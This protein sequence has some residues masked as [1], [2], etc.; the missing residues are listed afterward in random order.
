MLGGELFVPKIPSMTITDLAKTIAPKCRTKLVG[1]RPGEKLHE[2]MISADDARQTKELADCYI[3]QPAFPWWSNSNH[4]E[5]KD[6]SEG[7]SYSS[8]ANNDWLT[9]QQLQAMIKE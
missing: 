2:V 1:I 7:F 8:D 4:A 5:G 9:I 6:V 3:I